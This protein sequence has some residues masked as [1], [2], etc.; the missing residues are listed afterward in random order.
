MGDSGS[1]RGTRERETEAAALARVAKALS[2]PIRLEMVR[3]MS[4]GRDCCA[5]PDP[6]GRRV[7]GNGTPKGICVCEFQER[8]DLGQSRTSYH[9]RVLKEA[10]LVVE[11]QRGKWSFYSLDSERSASVLGAL[12]GFFGA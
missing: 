1:Q 5:L 10:G 12:R 8:F 7:P 3:L 4:I 11:E 2:D 6:A 9:L